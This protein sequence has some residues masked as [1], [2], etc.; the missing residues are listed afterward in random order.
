MSDPADLPIACTL[1]SRELRERTGELLPGLVRVAQ[2]SEELPDGRRYRFA[3][4]TDTLLA[5]MRVM[6]N[7]R[8]CCRFFRFRLTIEPDLGPF[9]LEVT[10]PPGVKEF[11][12]ELL[13]ERDTAC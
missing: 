10:G 12:S 2:D 5:I 13:T 9:W 7:E 3:A 8:Q 6:E 4:A 1:S 11:L